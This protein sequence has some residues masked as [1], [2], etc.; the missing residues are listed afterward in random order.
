MEQQ[1]VL[2]DLAI[3]SVAAEQLRSIA[4]WAKFLSIVG[5]IL[6]GLMILGGIF[7]GTIFSSMNA[8][9][10]G[11]GGVM[12]GMGTMI[13]VIYIIFAIIWFIPTLF[14]Y[15]SSAKFKVALNTADQ[16]LLNEGFMKLKATFRFWGIVT[17]ILL[18]FYAIVFLIAILGSAMR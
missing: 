3:D 16:T 10:G 9:G 14:L 18:S 15:Q 4:S 17:I 1:N 8:Y 11:Y 12:S 2:N 13:G 7:A 6:C 5:F